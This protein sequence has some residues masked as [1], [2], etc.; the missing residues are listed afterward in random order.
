MK[1]FTM[2]IL[3]ISMVFCGFSVISAEEEME[4][5]IESFADLGPD[6][7]LGSTYQIKEDALLLASNGAGGRGYG[8]LHYAHAIREFDIRAN[9]QV[10]VGDPPANWQAGYIGIRIPEKNAIWTHGIWV[11]FLET[12]KVNFR[13]NGTS[14]AVDIPFTHDK[15]GRDVRVTDREGL[16]SV[17]S[18]ADGGKEVLLA[19]AESDGGHVTIKDSS[20]KVVQV[21]ETSVV[22]YGYIGFMAHYNPTTIKNVRITT[23]GTI[24]PAEIHKYVKAP[25]P[26]TIPTVGGTKVNEI[27]G[28]IENVSW[29]W[30]G[31]AALNARGALSG[32]APGVF[33]P[34]GVLT[35]EQFI[36]LV[37]GGFELM[38]SGASTTSYSDVKEGEW[39]YSY[40]VSAEKAG[41]LDGIYAGTLGVGEPISRQDMVTVAKRALDKKGATLNFTKNAIAFEDASDISPYAGEAVQA[42]T[43]AGIVNGV[44]PTTFEPFSLCTRAMAAKVLCGLLNYVPNQNI[45]DTMSDTWVGADNLKREMYTNKQVGS[46]KKDKT[47]GIFFY[48]WH[49][50]SGITTIYDNSKIMPQGTGENRPWGPKSAMHYCQEPYFGYYRNSDEFVIRKNIQMLADAGVD[51]IYLDTTNGQLYEQTLVNTLKVMREMQNE[52]KKVPKFCFTINAYATATIERTYNAFYSKDLYKE[53]WFY[54]DGKPLILC[55]PE[56]M[57]AHLTDFFTVRRSWA[58]GPEWGDWF[59]NG[60]DKW[61]WL[62]VYPQEYGWHDNPAQPEQLVI[63]TAQHPYNNVGK[64]YHEGA[65]P[66]EFRT[67][68]GLFFAEQISRLEDVDPKVVMFTQWNE[69]IAARG[70]KGEGTSNQRGNEIIEPGET[71]FVDALNEEYNRDIEPVRGSYGDNYYYQMANAIRRFK[72]V[73]KSPET[74]ENH[75]IIIGN[76]FGTWQNVKEVYYDDV[77]DIPHRDSTAVDNKIKYVETSGRNDIV[78]AKTAKDSENL[79]F[80]VKTREN[81]TSAADSDKMHMVLYLNVDGDYNTGWYGYDYIIGRARKDGY[82]SVEK[83]TASGNWQWKVVAKAPYATFGNEKHFSISKADL[84]ITEGTFSVDFKWADNQG[85]T[86][87]IMEFIDKGEAAPNGRFNYRFTAK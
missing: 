53:L 4:I 83:C 25:V 34:D 58:E 23:A 44:T 84:G 32:T 2:L 54:W 73:R 15:V 9:I 1:K 8:T 77:Y 71:Y 39:Y 70:I 6:W 56:A 67:D 76:D 24:T 12:A 28:D 69:K 43:R 81:I 82:L 26:N 31:I 62:S 35:R 72:G 29:A 66:D 85:E 38:D 42:L 49:E 37:V 48:I 65:Q 7:T 18:T 10:T 36:K 79:Y 64:S 74:S 46:P 5:V 50:N 52:G 13:V 59:G 16:I 87:E 14:V 20:G 78:E 40:V 47:V 17:Y 57:P 86:P 55:P 61:P 41:L 30:E 3:V 19:T 80:Y 33:E 51:F 60:K 68:E 22:D 45:V 27:F 11:G 21:L 63:S 75:T